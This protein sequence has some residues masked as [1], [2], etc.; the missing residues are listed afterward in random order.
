MGGKVELAGRYCIFIF[1]YHVTE[2]THGKDHSR[3]Y[4]LP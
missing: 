2:L 3:R 4:T 1:Y